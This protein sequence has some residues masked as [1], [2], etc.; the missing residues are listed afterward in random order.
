MFLKEF[1]AGVVYGLLISILTAGLAKSNTISTPFNILKHPISISRGVAYSD[2]LGDDV[3]NRVI[4]LTESEY[5]KVW[6]CSAQ[7]PWRCILADTTLSKSPYCFT[8]LSLM[9]QRGTERI[10]LDCFNILCVFVSRN[11]STSRLSACSS[12]F[13]DASNCGPR[14]WKQA[15]TGGC[16]PFLPASGNRH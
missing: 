9:P 13:A 3:L 7:S 11:D 2:L 16:I 15:A 10:C 14:Y 12:S 1:L 5:S 6:L 8:T 4:D